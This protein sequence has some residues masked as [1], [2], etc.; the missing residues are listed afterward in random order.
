MKAR[1]GRQLI[2]TSIVGSPLEYAPQQSPDGVVSVGDLA[3]L[4]M[5]E[6]PTAPGKDY[7]EGVLDRLQWKDRQREINAD[8]PGTGFPA[9]S[10]V[11]KRGDDD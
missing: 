10:M 11:T 4:R 1:L 5:M 2:T 7:V 6:S 8:K 3:W 9:C